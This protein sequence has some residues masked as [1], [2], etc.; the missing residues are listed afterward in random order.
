MS[1]TQRVPLIF[2]EHRRR[3][4]AIE[5]MRMLRHLELECRTREEVD[6]IA[7]VIAGLLPDPLIGRLGVVELLLN[8]I[9][10]GNLEIGNALKGQLIREQRFEAELAARL[11]R[12]PYRA[13]RVHVVVD[14]EYPVVNIAIRDDGPGFDWRR[15]LA[16]E[17]EA[18]DAPNG[19]GI[20]LV[21]RTCFPTLEYRDP[22]NVA[23]VKLIWPR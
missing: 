7:D 12:E 21:S 6:G 16:S 9:E 18:H 17:V 1:I 22:G 2:A 4:G 5:V 23:V 13:R 15:A 20:A 3:T 10:H 19:R 8:A 14:V 11:D